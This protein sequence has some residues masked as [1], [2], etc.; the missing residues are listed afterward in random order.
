MY[1]AIVCK[2]PF[3][4]AIQVIISKL[5]RKTKRHK[6]LLAS[7]CQQKWLWMRFEH[8]HQLAFK[9]C[10]DLDSRLRLWLVWAWVQIP[11]GAT[12]AEIR[13]YSGLIKAY[14]M[15]ICLLFLI[16]ERESE[17]PQ[18]L[19]ARWLIIKIF[20]DFFSHP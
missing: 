1:S 2:Q 8:R 7:V 18:A 11:F 12:F 16:S 17:L 13:S 14:S 6:F 19:E 5:K 20:H 10:R 4:P 15:T 3:Y 9:D